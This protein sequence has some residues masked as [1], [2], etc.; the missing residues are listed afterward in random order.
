MSEIASITGVSITTVSNRIRR[1][2]A[3]GLILGYVANILP[4]PLEESRLL[5]LIAEF[6][7][8]A[9]MQTFASGLLQTPFLL[10]FQKEIIKTTLFSR[11]YLPNREFPALSDLLRSL[12]K[13]GFMKGFKIIELDMVSEQSRK[14]PVELLDSKGRWQFG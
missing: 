9:E 8:G 3:N 4:F 1:L 13:D 11:L 14:I 6:P 12:V 5:Q 7:G 2:T 10:S